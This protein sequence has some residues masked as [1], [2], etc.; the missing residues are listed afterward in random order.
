MA[1]LR[2]GLNEALGLERHQF[3]RGKAIDVILVVAVN[4][5]VLASVALT[6]VQPLFVASWASSL[7]SGVLTALIGW[8]LALAALYRFV[9]A[10]RP[11]GRI[12]LTAAGLAA[13]ALVVLEQGF[14]VY[15]TRFA[16]YDAVY[17]SLATVIAFLIF[18]YL[19]ATV[20]LGGPIVATA[21]RASRPQADASAE[22]RRD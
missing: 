21:W 14:S 15:A 18:I 16:D 9:P 11:D 7:S 5:V 8:F 17:G 22:P 19:S 2:I 1:S 10:S 20:V 3:V 6:L 4:T 13:V 12:A